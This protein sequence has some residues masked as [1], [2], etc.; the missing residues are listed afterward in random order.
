VL[1]LVRLICRLMKSSHMR[2]PRF[3]SLGEIWGPI[4]SK[5][6]VHFEVRQW[7]SG[8]RLTCGL[9]FVGTGGRVIPS[10]VCG[11]RLEVNSRTVYS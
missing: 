8:P 10:N 11:T 4:L 1:R 6:S 7:N 9:L 3:R 5:V 2:S